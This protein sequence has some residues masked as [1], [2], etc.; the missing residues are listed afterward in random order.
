MCDETVIEY[1]TRQV[2]YEKPVTRYDHCGR[3]YVDCATCYREVQVPV[4]K[5]VPLVKWQKVGL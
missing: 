2:A 3:P 5:T 4:R 1:V